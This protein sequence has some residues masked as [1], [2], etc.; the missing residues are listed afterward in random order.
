V[1]SVVGY[2]TT[3]QNGHEMIHGGI[4]SAEQ[5]SRLGEIIWNP[6][7]QGDEHEGDPA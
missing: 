6:A 2:R 3:R 1:A 5:R 7:M 4:I